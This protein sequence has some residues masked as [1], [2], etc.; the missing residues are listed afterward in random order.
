MTAKQLKDLQSGAACCVANGPAAD[1]VPYIGSSERYVT[2]QLRDYQ[3]DGVNWMIEQYNNGEVSEATALY[4]ALY[5]CFLSNSSNSATDDP[6]SQCS[7]CA[8]AT[9]LDPTSD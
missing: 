9:E 7:A 3:V 8:P 6:A 5:T 2:A 4:T 1:M